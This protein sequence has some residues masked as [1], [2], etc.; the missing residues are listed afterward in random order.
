MFPKRCVFDLY[1]KNLFL[2]HWST[3]VIF[4]KYFKISL[5]FSKQENT[6]YVFANSNIAPVLDGSRY[7]AQKYFVNDS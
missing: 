3:S 4:A 1:L 7:S 6:E 2:S 5:L